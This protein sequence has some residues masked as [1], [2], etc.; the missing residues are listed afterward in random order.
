MRQSPIETAVGIFVVIGIVCVSYLTIKL[1]SVELFGS[2]HYYLEARFQS[3]SGLK[4]GAAIEMAGVQVG[5]VESI[6]LDLKKQVAV[7]KLKIQK[8]LILTDDV[9]ASIKTSGLIGDRYI[10]LSPGG[11]DKILNQGD[12]ITETESAVDLEELVSKYVFGKV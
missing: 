11:S 7:V 9:I 12:V 1:G 2:D 3:V 5:K 6:F 10:S 8:E 4:K